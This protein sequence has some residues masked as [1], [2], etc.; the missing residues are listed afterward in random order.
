MHTTYAYDTS[1]ELVVDKYESVGPSSDL[2]GFCRALAQ[3]VE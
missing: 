1:Y 3:K 2:Y